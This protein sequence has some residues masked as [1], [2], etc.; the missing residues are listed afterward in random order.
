[1]N[2]L[3]NK[4]ALIIGAASGIGQAIA[5]LY[6][7]EG[8][9]LALAD[10]NQN[11][12]AS[13]CTAEDSAYRVDVSSAESVQALVN[14]VVERHGRID[15]LVNSAGILNECPITEMS[16]DIFDQMIAVNL[17]GVFLACHY[18]AP[19]MVE[20]R[21][22]RIINIASQLAHKG[23]IG[24]SHYS[25]A[26]AGILGMTKSMARELAPY[27]V[28][29]NAIAPG[30][31]STPLLG[32]VSSEWIGEKEAELPLGRFGK[33]EEVAPS[34]L[35]LAASPDGDLYL[36]QALGPNSGDVM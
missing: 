35:L 34:A 17:R 13:L 4:V 20:Q 2:K 12:C 32:D 22:G 33:P 29:T 9:T 21:S 19:L 10:L 15:I 31:I 27:N 6:Q 25:A 26:K 18:V 3:D 36:G 7:A 16:P 5:K 11:A 8:A 30:P 14:A 1:M 28:L 24:M 23:A